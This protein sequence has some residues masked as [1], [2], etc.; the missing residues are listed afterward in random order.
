MCAYVC[1]C[2]LFP[3]NFADIE[4]SD[5]HMSPVFFCVIDKVVKLERLIKLVD[6]RWNKSCHII[7]L[8]VKLVD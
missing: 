3:S 1:M 2:V 7:N 6:D 4:E 5:L 8:N